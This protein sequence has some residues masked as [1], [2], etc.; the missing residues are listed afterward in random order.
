MNV[1]EVEKF[2]DENGND[3]T[4]FDIDSNG[5]D[6]PSNDNTTDDEYNE[7]GK[8]GGDEDDNDPAAIEIFDLA[9]IKTVVSS[10]PY[11]D[12]SPVTYEMTI[13]NQGSLTGSG[14]EI[15]DHLPAGLT[16]DA[17]LNPDWSAVGNNA[18]SY[19]V[20]G[21]LTPGDEVKAT[22][23]ATF[24]L[25][26]ATAQNYTNLAEISDNKDEEGNPITDADSMPDGNPN[27]DG[28]PIDN[29]LT[30]RGDEDDHDPETLDIINDL[31]PDCAFE[32]QLACTFEINLSLNNRTCQT[33]LS[34]SSL[35]AGID[36]AGNSDLFYSLELMAESGNR[37]EPT[38]I[39]AE[40]IGKRLSY[41]ITNICNNSCWGY[42]NVQYKQGPTIDCPPVVEVNCFTIDL[43]CE[44]AMPEVNPGCLVD[45]VSME[46]T[47]ESIE[48]FDCGPTIEI[49]RSYRATD[50]FG[51]T[52]ECEQTLRLLPVEFDDIAY[53]L[54]AQIPC[55]LLY[56]SPSP[57]DRG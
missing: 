41:R 32:C 50:T 3:I 17:S 46:L 38:I 25:L 26:N 23:V 42:V 57:R 5:D 54:S 16:F 20:P 4:S 37:I 36:P 11:V 33:V 43:G 44:V 15:T 22:F 24:V 48:V 55:C 53:P 45:V 28:V 31:P 47:E 14:I 34:P 56:T 7:D 9:M 27:N 8:T 10:G 39:T 19:S 35:V 6:D 18:Y 52:D 51:N 30:D 13:V 21:S 12:G 29:Q 1:A 2:E 40:H 49:Y